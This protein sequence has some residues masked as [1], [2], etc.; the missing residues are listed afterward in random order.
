[1]LV[2]VLKFPEQAL[3]RAKLVEQEP[4]LFYTDQTGGGI[5]S[6][7]TELLLDLI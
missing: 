2:R 7:Q 4:N 1:M 3:H 6:R 5:L